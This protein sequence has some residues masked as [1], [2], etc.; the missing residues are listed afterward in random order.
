M[1]LTIKN[2]RLISLRFFYYIQPLFWHRVNN[3]A[4]L[5]RI[6]FAAIQ[7]G[8]FQNGSRFDYFAAQFSDQLDTCQHC[9]AGCHQIIYQ[10]NA[11]ARLDGVGMDF[12]RCFAIFQS[13]T[14]RNRIKRQF[15]LFCGWGQSRRFS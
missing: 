2:R 4:P 11:C 15:C 6:F 5:S 3:G 7:V 8:K 12:Y 9:A 13:V 14:L 1:I 10:Q